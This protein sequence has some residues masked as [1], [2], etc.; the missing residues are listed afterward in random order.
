MLENFAGRLFR[1]G[2]RF[3]ARVREKTAHLFCKDIERDVNKQIIIVIFITVFLFFER[4]RELGRA[5][6]CVAISLR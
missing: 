6:E 2:W 4:K 3:Y 1:R 5:A